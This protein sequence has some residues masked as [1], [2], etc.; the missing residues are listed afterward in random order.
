MMEPHIDL[1]TLAVSDL[2]RS[3]ELYRDGLGL[4]SCELVGTE[5]PGDDLTPAGAAAMRLPPELA[6]RSS[7]P[8][9][10]ATAASTLLRTPPRGRYRARRLVP[11]TAGGDRRRPRRGSDRCRYLTRHPALGYGDP[12]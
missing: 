4:E 9:P 6:P 10:G 12:R 7:P 5:Y 1:I 2:E 3:F 8:S 11:P